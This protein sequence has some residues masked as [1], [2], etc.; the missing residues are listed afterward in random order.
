MALSLKKLNTTESKA[1]PIILAYGVDGVGKSSLAAEFPDAIYISTRG[2]NPPSDVILPTP[3]TV[4]TFADI[5]S[6]FG[7]LIVED[8]EF[9]SVI[10]DSLDG[11]ESIFNAETCQRIGANAIGSNESGS[12]AAY[13]QGD[14]ESEVEW[15]EFF[16]ACD[17]L[18]SQGICVILLAH[19]EIKRFDSPVSDPYDRY[20]VKL[21]KRA[22]AFICEKVDIIAFLNYRISIKTKEV[23]RQKTVSHAE[24]GKDRIINLT[25]GAGF[26]AKNRYNM[27]DSIKYIKGKGFE[28]LSKYFPKPTG[29]LTADNDNQGDVE[30]EQDA[31]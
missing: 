20:K 23:A 24:G 28:E 25:E 31:A 2:E 5:R 21:R 14:V 3:G 6:V 8:H 15:G 12:P 29:K 22:T 27:P 19:P 16:D 13:G 4:E 17:E 18:K 9:K 1:P 7:D 30:Q 11:L 26:V 10:V